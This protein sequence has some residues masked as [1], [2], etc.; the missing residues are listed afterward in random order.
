MRIR[1]IEDGDVAGVVALWD[2]CARLRSWNDPL[3]DIRFARATRDSQIFIGL[4]GNALAAA[5]MCGH[6]GHRGWLYYLAVDPERWGERFGRAM[7]RH[8]EDWLRGL[9]V[10]KVELMIRETNAKVVRFYDALDY[11]TEPV[12]TMSRWLR[13]LPGTPHD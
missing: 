4:D 2:R 3:A 9:G 1:A 6:D 5:I 7:V 12:I 8:A 13:Q 11:Q 10:P